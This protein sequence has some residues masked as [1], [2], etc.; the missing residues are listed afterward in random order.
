M[1]SFSGLHLKFFCQEDIRVT[2]RIQTQ[3]INTMVKT[4]AKEDPILDIPRICI[5]N[6]SAVNIAAKDIQLQ[7]TLSSITNKLPSPDAYRSGASGP[8][9]YEGPVYTAPSI[10]DD[11]VWESGKSDPLRWIELESSSGQPISISRHVSLRMSR[12]LSSVVSTMMQH[13]VDMKDTSV[14]YT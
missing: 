13:G 3:T 2:S 11:R 8:D 5:G 4:N 1:C 9:A 7:S 6:S 10:P 12:I 14:G